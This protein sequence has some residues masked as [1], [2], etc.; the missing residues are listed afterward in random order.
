MSHSFLKLDLNSW[1]ISNVT[2]CNGFSY[3]A[4]AWTLPKP[5]F[6]NCNTGD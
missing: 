3:E 4:S 5:N 1:N 2:E 6:T